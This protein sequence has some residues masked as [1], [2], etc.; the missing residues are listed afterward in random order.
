MLESLRSIPLTGAIPMAI[1][2]TALLVPFLLVLLPFLRHKRTKP[3][4][5]SVLTAAV[6]T[7]AA[8]AA[9]VWLADTPPNQL[10][11]SVYLAIFAWLTTIGLFI[12]SMAQK[13]F[14]WS[15]IGIFLAVLMMFFGGTLIT[16][17]AYDQYPDIDS[18]NPTV[19][20]NELNAA[21]IPQPDPQH[22]ALP[23]PQW[24]EQRSKWENLTA[25][26]PH[27]GARVS[28]PVP[29]PQ[30][31]FHVRNA[32]VYLPP[33]WFASPRP[34]LPVL[35][36]MHGTPG[37]PAQWFEE[38]GVARLVDD[39]Q[40][41]HGGIAPIVASIDSTGDYAGNPLCTDSSHGNVMTYLTK[42]IPTWLK[43]RFSANPDQNTWT[44]GG[45]SYG[46]T[47][48]FQV[49]TNSPSS[50]GTFLDYSGELL[51][52]DGNSHQTTVNNFFGGSE[53]IYKQRNPEDI[54]KKAIAEK[55]RRFQ[56]IAGRFVSGD[57]EKTGQSDLSTLN[58]LANQAGMDTTFR[59]LSGG[60]D[61]G[62]W[63]NALVQDFAFTTQR[64]GLAP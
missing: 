59:T 12:A 63:R 43:E 44:L 32:E 29:T 2:W 42:D 22:P 15:T 35:T 14:R 36:L 46:G 47:C 19:H 54:L 28:M 17:Q 53:D 8:V 18:L 38:G 51:P 55:D 30:S 3:L 52:N 16:N 39:Y 24:Q 58:D 9:T 41:T 62:V 26:M 48:A 7:A 10:R 49:A 57:E 6:L 27:K 11:P 4:L 40:R 45:L 50:F 56:G 61:Y 37:E 64:G 13:F 5:L 20:Y 21:D 1:A 33:A 23:L 60:H 31:G 34:Q 25:H